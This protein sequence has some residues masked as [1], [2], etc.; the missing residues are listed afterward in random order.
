MALDRDTFN[1][2]SFGPS[3]N[4]SVKQVRVSHFFATPFFSIAFVLRLFQVHHDALPPPICDC[5]FNQRFHVYPLIARTPP[6]TFRPP[7]TPLLAFVTCYYNLQFC[8]TS[9]SKPT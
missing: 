8:E 3:L 6:T 9:Y 5:D 7:P 2:K 1:R 4:A